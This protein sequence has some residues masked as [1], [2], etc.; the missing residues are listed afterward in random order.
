MNLELD[1]SVHFLILVEIVLIVYVLSLAKWKARTRGL[2]FPPGPKGLPIVGNM[3]NLP[4]YRSWITYRD[5]SAEYGEPILTWR[6][7]NNS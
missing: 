6:R 5:A 3:F 7:A 2:P 4:T 1:I